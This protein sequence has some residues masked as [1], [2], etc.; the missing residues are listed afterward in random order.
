[1]KYTRLAAS[2]IASGLLA[3]ASVG[4]GDLNPPNLDGK[5]L[6]ARLYH[7]A[8][9]PEKPYSLASPPAEVSYEKVELEIKDY[10]IE[11]DLSD[12]GGKVI[13]VIIGQDQTDP[14][15]IKAFGNAIWAA[16]VRTILRCSFEGNAARFDRPLVWTFC[17]A[18]GKPLAN[19]QVDV[20]LQDRDSGNPKVF[21]ATT[22][23]NGHVQVPALPGRFHTV[24]VV[25]S[26]PGLGSSVLLS[27]DI[28]EKDS[29]FTVAV[30]QPCPEGDARTARG[31]VVDNEGKAVAGVRVFCKSI[32]VP[33]EGRI[34]CP[35]GNGHWA[36]TGPDGAFAICM[37][38]EYF[39]EVPADAV[40]H[41]KYSVHVRPPEALGIV[42]LHKELPLGRR[43][44]V[45]L[46]PQ[47]LYF[48]T[49]VFQDANGAIM[50]PNRL[51]NANVRI[52]TPAGRTQRYFSTHVKNGAMLALGR[53][54]ARIEQPGGGMFFEPLDVTT[55]SP[56]QLVFRMQGPQET[57][58]AGQALYAF[59]HQPIEGAFAVLANAGDNEN[60]TVAM[61][62]DEQWQALYQLVGTP[63]I[64]EPAL[65][66]L[67]EI[68][69]IEK[70]VRTGPAG[71]FELSIPKIGYTD[72]A[73]KICVIEQ[74]CM[75][76][77]HRLYWSDKDANEVI[78]LPPSRLLP[79]AKVAFSLDYG[80]EEYLRAHMSW[81]LDQQYGAYY[82]S[83]IEYKSIKGV[84]LPL[85]KWMRCGQEPFLVSIPA[86]ISLRLSFQMHTD[87]VH[88]PVFTKSIKA[89]PGDYIDLGPIEM[90]ETIPVYVQVLDPNGNPVQAVAVKHSKIADDRYF[91]QTVITDEYGMAEFKVPLHFK[92]NF[93]ISLR[94]EGGQYLREDIAYETNG[95]EDA[96]N[97]Y[98][99][100]LS[101]E[102]L[103]AI[104]R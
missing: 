75:P 64:N 93:L 48:R 58:L 92:A 80:S 54:R 104:F 33:G 24:E 10:A 89:E 32:A 43:T 31:V 66:P 95:P 30:A 65:K 98:T 26:R 6:V 11:A 103:E 91:G 94:D 97:V 63:D 96:N 55:D 102:M 71:H 57:T 18:L 29:S 85:H 40:S 28:V 21:T 1:M 87:R 36:L 51:D 68:W 49:F 27:S 70:A 35:F 73:Y 84:W 7:G 83:F 13:V 101:D 69:H 19:A 45:A 8:V 37:P 16:K 52:D 44:V 38:D 99:L 77:Y 72:H 9:E 50:D 15:V 81:D 14:A 90:G 47:E 82:D 79:A 3:A 22:G 78:L 61:L 56:Q 53:Y 23:A 86:G 59:T 25:L 4:A 5:Y 2:I 39:A 34:D 46:G 67:H 62:S 76:V 60:R 74:G 12:L 42:P 20:H 17:D 100:R 88:T 41:L